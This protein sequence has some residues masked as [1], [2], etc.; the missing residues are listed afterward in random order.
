MTE[1]YAPVVLFTHARYDTAVR[2]MES[3]KSCQEFNDTPVYVYLDFPQKESYVPENLR[4]KK[5]FWY[6]I[7]AIK[8]ITV[9]VMFKIPI[10][11]GVKFSPNNKKL[12]NA[13]L[14]I[15]NTL[16]K[17]TKDMGSHR[18]LI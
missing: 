14:G 12:L 1:N 16:Y 8:V 17:N 11:R 2:V 18:L 13:A 10:Y 15:C 9:L 7:I 5:Y 3:L 4:L 6:M